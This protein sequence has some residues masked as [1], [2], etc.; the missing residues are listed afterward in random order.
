MRNKQIK[1]NNCSIFGL[2]YN[3]NMKRAGLVLFLNILIIGVMLPVFGAYYGN[4]PQT[5]LQIARNAMNSSYNANSKLVRVGIG[6]QNFSSYVR[7]SASI[8]GTGEFEIYNK[9]T[10]M[11]T[12]DSNNQVNISMVGK[13]FVLTD[14]EGNVI[15]K[16]SGPIIFKTDFGFLGIKDLKRGGK[17]AVYRGRLELICAGEGKFYV[18]NSLDVEDYLKGVV[19][20]EMPVHFGL[21]ALKAQAVAARNYV[22]SPRVKANP[23]YDVVD[24]VASQVYYGANTEKDLSNQAVDETMGIVATYNW[25]LILALY[26]STAGGYTE[27]YENAFSDPKTK[28]FPADSKPYLKAVPDNDNLTPLNTEE[29]AEKFYTTKPKSFDVNS[30]YYRWEREWTQEELQSEIQNNIVAQSA[31]GFVH[32]VVQKGETIGKILRLEVLER[33]LS[34]KIMRLQ[35]ETDNGNYIAEKELVIRRLFTNKGK[36]LP[37]ANLVFKQK[38]DDE[39]NLKTIKAYGGGY[40]HGVGMSQFG[41]GYMATSLHLPYEKILQHYYSG[42]SLTTEPF[43][44]SSNSAQNRV[45]QTFFAKNGEGK[46]IVDNKYKVRY[47]DAC[48]NNVDEKIELD[49]SQRINTINISKYLQKGINTITFYYP[50]SSGSNKGLRMYVELTGKYDYSN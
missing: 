36:A 19:P 17:D 42:I 16:V 39:G 15:N 50:L 7:E 28:V 8:Y 34:G 21:E 22:L 44:I 24:S 2:S 46:L 32:P 27:S 33:G 23:N 41:A 43:I 35:I 4:I 29:E 31:A 14:I 37:S 3:K 10:Y 26:S 47:I 9:N 49:T 48:I 1:L 18:V 30:S 12:L 13:I 40:G 20:N 45:T 25:D 5:T 11:T 38:F 6:N